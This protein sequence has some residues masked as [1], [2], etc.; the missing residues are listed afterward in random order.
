MKTLIRIVLIAI[1]CLTHVENVAAERSFDEAYDELGVQRSPYQDF[2][3]RFNSDVLSPSPDVVDFMLNR[4]LDDSRKAWPVPLVLGTDEYARVLLGVRQRAE[5]YK[6][7]F[8]DV[9]MGEQRAFRHFEPEFRTLIEELFRDDGL[10]LGYLRSH[11]RGL[12]KTK[13]RFTYA[14]DLVRSPAGDW[15]VLEDNVGYAPGGLGDVDSLRS[16]YLAKTGID[17]PH[18]GVFH[19]IIQSFGEDLDGN[20]EDLAAVVFESNPLDFHSFDGEQ[21]RI[22]NAFDDRLIPVTTVPNEFD[23]DLHQLSS[24]RKII[25]LDPVKMAP[26]VLD[27]YVRNIAAGRT[28]PFVTPGTETLSHKALLP[29]MD[30]LAQFYLGEG[31]LLR[32]PETRAIGSALDLVRMISDLGPDLVVKS[33][34]GHSGRQVYLLRELTDV[35]KAGLRAVIDRSALESHIRNGS[36]LPH[37]QIVAQPFVRSS[38]LSMAAG[39][40]APRARIDIRPIA[41]VGPKRIVLPALP[42]GRATTRFGNTRHNVGFGAM[43]LVVLTTCDRALAS[44]NTED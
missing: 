2:S 40:H 34:Y 24:A 22:V 37:P 28:E 14:P 17:L 7:L 18:V 19:R 27:A 41:Y 21:D 13:V 39:P 15:Q 16:K 5:V 9:V 35:Q 20:F 11:F 29:W 38:E 42:W 30:R 25:V 4:P 44:I 43:H 1:S 23:V 8:H 26:N 12:D 36:A 3:H 33:S 32:S 31:L 6:Y 10:S